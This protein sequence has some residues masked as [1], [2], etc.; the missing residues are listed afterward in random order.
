ME[1]VPLLASHHQV[2]ASIP[3]SDSIT[4]CSHAVTPVPGEEGSSSFPPTPISSTPLPHS[5]FTFHPE[6]SSPHHQRPADLMASIDVEV[7]VTVNIESG[8]IKLRSREER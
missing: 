5:T 7:N 1:A 8:I 6:G 2:S 3:L 4:P